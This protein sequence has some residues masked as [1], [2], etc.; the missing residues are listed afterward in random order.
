MLLLLGALAVLG[1]VVVARR[2]FEKGVEAVANAVAD[3]LASR[4]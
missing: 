4:M 2:A 1:A 3:E